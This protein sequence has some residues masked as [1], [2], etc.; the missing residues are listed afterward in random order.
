[1]SGQ[2]KTQCNIVILNHRR[3]IIAKNIPTDTAA[4]GVDSLKGHHNVTIEP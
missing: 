2:R 4:K 3:H 1:M